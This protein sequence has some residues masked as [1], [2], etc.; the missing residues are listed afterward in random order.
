MRVC[1]P[2]KRFTACAPALQ[3][4][5]PP[6]SAPPLAPQ[7]PPGRVQGAGGAPCTCVGGKHLTLGLLLLVLRLLP[8]EAARGVHPGRARVGQTGAPHLRHP[9]LSLPLSLWSAAALPPGLRLPCPR[10]LGA[11]PA[12]TAAFL[13][14]LCAVQGWWPRCA[15]RAPPPL[16]LPVRGRGATGGVR[17]TGGGAADARAARRRKRWQTTPAT[18]AT[19]S[20]AWWYG[21]VGWPGVECA[22]LGALAR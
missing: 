6:S 13:D 2:P 4:A 22:R 12:W 3:A 17:C 21:P 16:L 8:R 18:P 7:A 5:P 9:R 20:A 11:R 14:A 15:R 1:P 10:R 19:T